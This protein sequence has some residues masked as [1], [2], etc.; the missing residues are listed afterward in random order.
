MAFGKVDNQAPSTCIVFPSAA[1]VV[2]VGA[3]HDADSV[4]RH[5]SRSSCSR[6]P[7]SKPSK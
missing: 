6:N 5:S 1:I 7:T 2:K 3:E 4:D